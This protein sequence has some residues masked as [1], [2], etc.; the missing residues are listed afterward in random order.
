MKNEHTKVAWITGGGTGIGK[1]LTKLL[2]N[3]GW[4]I[5][6]SGR[7]LDKL[8]EVKKFKKDK[9][10]PIQLDISSKTQC[11]NVIKKILDKFKSIDLVFLNAAAYN[12][13]HLDFSNLSSLENII[14]VNITGQL[15]C[16]SFLMPH[17]K[18]K[19]N[20]KIVFVSSPAGFRGLP[21]AGIYGVTKSAITFLA[22]S[23]HIEMLKF[24]IKVQVVHPGFVKTPMTDKNDFPMPFLMTS[25]D[26]AKR[27]YKK[28]SSNDFEI[29]FPKRLIWPM[30][31]LQ[32]LPYK[33]YF[34]VMKRITKFA[35]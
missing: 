2:A 8:N 31:L 5:V 33:I 4:T 26:A 21:N 11:K 18:K 16:L 30:K 9:I 32:I 22:E 3:K 28:L 27:I 35:S 23:L 15:N 7:R 17:L 24:N 10:V 12:P 14:R 29:Y 19:R 13:G 1:E 34:F 6:I 20:G 25:A